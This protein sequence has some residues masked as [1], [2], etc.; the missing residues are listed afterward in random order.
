MSSLL[1]EPRPEGDR[2]DGCVPLARYLMN[3]TEAYNTEDWDLRNQCRIMIDLEDTLNVS[4][5]PLFNVNKT[6]GNALGSIRRLPIEDKVKV[7]DV[8]KRLM[9][10]DPKLFSRDRWYSGNDDLLRLKLKERIA[11]EL[12]M[13]HNILGTNSKLPRISLKL[14]K[15]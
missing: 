3:H 15:Q 5:T 4:L 7:L 8:A 13:Y 9:D 11:R 12:D 14:K 1:S 6:V 2:W 10:I